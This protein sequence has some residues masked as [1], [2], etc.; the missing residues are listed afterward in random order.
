MRRKWGACDMPD[1]ASTT[2]IQLSSDKGEGLAGSGYH[3]R[4]KLGRGMH[5]A[6]GWAP[7][8]PPSP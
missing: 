6:P 3:C 7:S 4:A 1:A 8:R 2:F 5:I